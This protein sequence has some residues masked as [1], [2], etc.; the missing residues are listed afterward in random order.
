MEFSLGQPLK[1]TSSVA[2]TT[3]CWLCDAGP[4]SL[5]IL[6]CKMNLA[7]TLL[8]CPHKTPLGSNK[9]NGCASKSVKNMRL[10]AN[11]KKKVVIP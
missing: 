2:S 10:C 6:I 7:S 9:L 5:S 11:V 1:D 4:S 3:T 8:C